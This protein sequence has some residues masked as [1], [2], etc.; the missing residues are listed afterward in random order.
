[1][2]DTVPRLGMDYLGLDAAKGVGLEDLG[3]AVSLLEEVVHLVAS[4]R[5]AR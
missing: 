5:N 4:A 2:L 1:M 3:D